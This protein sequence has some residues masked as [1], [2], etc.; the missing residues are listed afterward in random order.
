MFKNTHIKKFTAGLLLIIFSFS[1][2]PRIFLHNWLA[3]HKDAVVNTTGKVQHIN[4]P[5]FNCQCDD[6]VAESPFIYQDNVFK[7]TRFQPISI[8]QKTKPVT[9]K[10]QAFSMVDFDT[11]SWYSV[12]L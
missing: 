6:N 8:R 2:T 1:I 12:T 3:N 11:K 5:V 4:A 7:V 10:W 9:T